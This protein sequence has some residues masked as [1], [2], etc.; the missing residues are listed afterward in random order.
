[1]TEMEKV[2]AVLTNKIYQSIVT[3]LAYLEKDRIY[4]KHDIEHFLAVA[5]IGYI[6]NLEEGL[7]IDKEIIYV[8]ALLHDIGRYLEYKKEIPHEQASI[9]ISK[10]I[11]EQIRFTQEE[12]QQILYAI[13]THRIEE[14]STNE[15]YKTV[16]DL[17]YRADK[18]S[19]N[20]F[21]C[22]SY[23][24]CYWKEERKNREIKL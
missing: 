13:Q 21:L 2:N 20:C 16:K 9:I 14:N 7:C 15:F 24:R 4:C 8:T 10:K 6:I 1:M 23:K 22:N 18:L 12:Q 19:R 3:E 5:R 11:L 17:I